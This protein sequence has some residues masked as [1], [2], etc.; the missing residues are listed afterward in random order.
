MS[1]PATSDLL[2][3]AVNL[4]HQI[5]RRGTTTFRG[6]II[7]L[8]LGK[9]MMIAFVLRNQAGL[10]HYVLREFAAEVDLIEEQM[11]IE[12]PLKI[13]GENAKRTA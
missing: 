5:G 12:N 13:G 4:E 1:I 11:G 6:D 2:A 7:G 8:F 3:R 10:T 9:A